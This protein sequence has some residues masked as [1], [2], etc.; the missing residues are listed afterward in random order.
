[1]QAKDY[2]ADHESRI[3]RLEFVVEEIGKT[4]VRLEQNMD[5]LEQKI[6]L[7]AAKFDKK[8]DYLGNRI[9]CVFDKLNHKI[10]HLLYFTIAGF[11]G[12]LGV[13]AHVFHWF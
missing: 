10:D 5:R 3:V 13:M 4:L 1:V 2:Q 11:T 6:D 12:I 9:D 7:L 8:Y